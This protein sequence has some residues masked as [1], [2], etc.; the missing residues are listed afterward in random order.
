MMPPEDCDENA[1]SSVFNCG[2][3]VGAD[4]ARDGL[5]GGL[6]TVFHGRC[7]TPPWDDHF[8]Q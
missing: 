4:Q 1:S 3:Q 8:L 5:R 6:E 7:G 2:F